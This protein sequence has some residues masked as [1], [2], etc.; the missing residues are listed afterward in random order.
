MDYKVV[1]GELQKTFEDNKDISF[2]EMTKFIVGAEKIVGVGAGRVGYSLKSFIMRLKHFNLDSYMLGDSNVPRTGERDLLIVASGSGET[3]STLTIVKKAKEYGM[4]IFGI[5]GKE[6]S[7]IA[8][9]CDAKLVLR[10]PESIQPMTTLN[11]QSLL[12]LF[13]MYVLELQKSIKMDNSQMKNNHSIL[14]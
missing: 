1:L 13:D 12:L 2:E 10:I 5:L 9:L 3:K 14:E 8:E 6:E 7:S 11:E 4:K